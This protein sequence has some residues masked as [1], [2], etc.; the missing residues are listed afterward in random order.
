MEVFVNSQPI[1][2]PSSLVHAPDNTYILQVRGDSL[3]DEGIQD[4]DFVLIEARQDIQAGE[5]ILGLINQH[6][7]VLKRYYPEGQ[8][9]RLKNQN[10]TNN[11]LQVRHEHISIQ[12]V[13]GRLD[14][15]VLKRHIP[16]ILQISFIP[17]QMENR[18]G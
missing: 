14:Q 11:S 1:A 7:T 12:G 3:R 13:Y 6:D 17:R 18:Y 10:P 4:G 2:V 16:N 5:I 15:N 8:Y 9:I